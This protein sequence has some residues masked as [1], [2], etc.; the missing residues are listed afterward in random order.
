MAILR[1]PH[2][3]R[4]EALKEGGAVGV[5]SCRRGLRNDVGYVPVKQKSPVQ[6]TGPK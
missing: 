2:L 1:Q 5:G 4:N 3:G 6:W